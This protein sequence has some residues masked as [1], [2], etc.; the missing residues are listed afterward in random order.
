MLHFAVFDDCMHILNADVGIP[1][2]I[3]ARNV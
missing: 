1:I 2:I 3:S